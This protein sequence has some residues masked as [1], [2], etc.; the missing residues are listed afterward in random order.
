MRAAGREI[1]P[2]IV[3]MFPAADV[4]LRAQSGVTSRNVLRNDSFVDSST[5]A[6]FPQIEDVTKPVS[7]PT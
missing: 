6:A 2:T 4:S 7:A 1:T 5:W 3:P